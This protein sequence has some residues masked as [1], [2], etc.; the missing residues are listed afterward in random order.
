M[1]A[2]Q[3]SIDFTNSVRGVAIKH[4]QETFTTFRLGTWEEDVKENTD[5]MLVCDI[6]RN[7]RFGYR[8]RTYQFR[9][10]IGEFTI[11]SK[12]AYGGTNTELHKIRQGFGDFMF[13]G[14]V[15]KAGTD[16]EAW[17]VID[18]Q[19][20]R[21]FWSCVQHWESYIGAAGITN[22]LNG[23]EFCAFTFGR[24]VPPEVIAYGPVLHGLDVVTYWGERTLEGIKKGHYKAWLK[25]GTLF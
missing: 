10:Y 15:D 3:H 17:M 24:N 25:Q 8:S 7:T 9:K 13:Y 22:Q 6:D 5:F 14:H 2:S 21:Q 4:L 20:L 11:R 19:K 18:L 1:G 16:Y 12:T 23:D